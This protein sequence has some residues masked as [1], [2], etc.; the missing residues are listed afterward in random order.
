MIACAYNPIPREVETRGSLASQSNHNSEFPVQGE[1][2]SHKNKVDSSWGTTPEVDLWPS[3]MCALVH[4]LTQNQFW[5]YVLIFPA[6]EEKTSMTCTQSPLRDMDN[7]LQQ[8]QFISSK[9]RKQPIKIQRCHSDSHLVCLGEG[10]CVGLHFP[11]ATFNN[12]S[13]M[14]Q[15]PSSPPTI[16][17]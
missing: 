16:R 1:I 13:Q 3:Y 10:V 7:I 14:V 4:T 17:G 12:G 9:G 5:L 8:G 11:K 6:K 2:W 15:P